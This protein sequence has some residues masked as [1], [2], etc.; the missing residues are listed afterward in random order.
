MAS[1]GNSRMKVGVVLPMAEDDETGQ[2][3]PYTE[4]RARALQAEAA[5]FDAIWLFDHLL[6]RFPDKPTV[7][8]WEAWT[9]LCAL[10]EGP[11]A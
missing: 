3:P 11:S 5:G 1:P 2:T 10:A 9:L 6:F 4:I 8:I 7:G